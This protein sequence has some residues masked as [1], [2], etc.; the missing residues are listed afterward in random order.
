MMIRR[1]VS[2]ENV[3][4]HSP[5]EAEKIIKNETTNNKPD[6]KSDNK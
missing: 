1:H 6:K 5:S 4:V 2:K 3:T